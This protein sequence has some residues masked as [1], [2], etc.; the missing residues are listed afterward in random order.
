MNGK[1]A[2][3]IRK[4]IGRPVLGMGENHLTGV[5]VYAVSG[6]GPNKHSRF[7]GSVRTNDPH[8]VIR[9]ATGALMKGGRFRDLAEDHEKLVATPHYFRANPAGNAYRQVKAK[10]NDTHNNV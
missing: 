9:D 8:T 7:I 3:A 6:K 4:A 10:L 1:K 2:K 5:A